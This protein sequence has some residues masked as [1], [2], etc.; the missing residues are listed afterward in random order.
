LEAIRASVR[1]AT[2]KLKQQFERNI[3]L[4]AQLEESD[5]K[6]KVVAVELAAAKRTEKEW[7]QK[8]PKEKVGKDNKAEENCSSASCSLLG[9]MPI[10]ELGEIKQNNKTNS[11]KPTIIC[12]LYCF[13]NFKMSEM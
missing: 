4:K 8:E 3:K 9:Y 12:V 6:L 7:I 13:I 11:G 5:D 1:K 2:N 10:L